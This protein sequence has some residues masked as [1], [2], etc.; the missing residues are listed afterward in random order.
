MNYTE[1]ILTSF[2]KHPKTIIY[3]NDQNM[4]I[5]SKGDNFYSSTASDIVDLTDSIRIVFNEM[6]IS[7]GN[8]FYWSGTINDE[9]KWVFSIG[10]SSGEGLFLTMNLQKIDDKLFE[11]LRKII[12]FFDGQFKKSIIKKLHDG[13]F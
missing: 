9:I 6:K 11:D 13:Y 10:G 7:G 3:E 4:K 12:V 1:T 8:S 5:L 2:R